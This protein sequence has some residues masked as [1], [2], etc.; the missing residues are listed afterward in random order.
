MKQNIEFYPH[1]ANADQHAKFKMLRVQFGW[2]G[3][4]RFWA[5]NN[6]I[7]LSEECCLDISK[8]Y[9][10]AALASDLNFTID[11]FNKFI[12]FLKDDCELIE[13]RG[14]GIITTDIIQETFVKVM[15][16]RGK[17]RERHRRTS[18]EKIKT[19]DEKTH[20]VKD[21]KGKNNEKEHTAFDNADFYI[22]KNKR[23]ITGKRLE[24]FMLFWEAFGY[25]RGK[26]EATDTWLDIPT[27]TDKIVN[28]II[29]SA[30]AEAKRRPGLKSN[31]GKPKMAQGWLSGKR[32]EDEIEQKQRSVEPITNQP[33]IKDIL[34]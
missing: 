17:A 1:Y 32:W 6:R 11:E 8:K 5:L 27:L 16:E 21:S 33:P 4:G 7:A 15:Q 12:I 30:K 23:K 28:E 2:E 24:T 34:S 10:K 13:E 18:G 19:S 29:I 26:A 22:T 31:G 14:N 9:N 20:I 3:E 25:K